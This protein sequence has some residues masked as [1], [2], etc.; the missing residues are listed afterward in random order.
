MCV[1]VSTRAGVA[2]EFYGTVMRQLPTSSDEP[3]WLADVFLNSLL[4][5]IFVLSSLDD[6]AILGDNSEIAARINSASFELT[7]IFNRA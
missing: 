1:H 5:D 2:I 3:L 7:Y 4:G 6:Q